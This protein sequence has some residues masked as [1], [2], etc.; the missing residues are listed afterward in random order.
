MI[1]LRFWLRRLEK[2]ITVGEKSRPDRRDQSDAHHVI[3]IPSG[4]FCRPGLLDNPSI[5]SHF[6]PSCSAIDSHLIFNVAPC[7]AAYLQGLTL[8]FALEFYCVW[9]RT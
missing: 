7:L 6:S 5:H 2:E 3:D 9:T 1:D 8:H 4:P